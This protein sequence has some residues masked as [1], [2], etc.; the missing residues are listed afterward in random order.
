[1][2][3][4][5]KFC[6]DRAKLNLTIDIVLL[7]LLMTMAGIGFL[8]KYVLLSGE[9][10]NVI[11]G[12][13]I[14]L[15]LLGMDRHQWG[16]IHLIISITF[17]V[18][19]LLHIIFH[20]KMIGC[21]F[22]RL[23]PQRVPRIIFSWGISALG[24]FLLLFAFA[25]EPNQVEYGN[26]YRHRERTAEMALEDVMMVVD[27]PEVKAAVKPHSVPAKLNTDHA[28]EHKHKAD[29]DEYEVKGTQTLKQISTQYNVPSSYI[30][31]ELGIPERF[32][33]ER[34][35]RLRKRYNFTMS[36]V[37]RAIAKYKNSDKQ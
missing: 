1:M 19:I 36:D 3:S 34:L 30:C 24:L 28:K 35:G 14:N 21:F 37:S 27:T 31:K 33:S 32:A 16:T 20:W 7:L 17:L 6:K 11:Y 26:L 8:I 9:K 13:N 22:K 5:I 2:N 25:I 4:F 10:R 15:E 12:Q 18:F 23:I 29:I